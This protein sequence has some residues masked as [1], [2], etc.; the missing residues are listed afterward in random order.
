MEAREDGSGRALFNKKQKGRREILNETSKRKAKKWKH[1]SF[2]VADGVK[3][4][5]INENLEHLEETNK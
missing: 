2:Q 5:S 3:Q 4:T 1:V